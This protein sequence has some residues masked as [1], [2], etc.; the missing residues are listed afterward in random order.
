MTVANAAS[1]SS[2]TASVLPSQFKSP[3]PMKVTSV[4]LR[5]ED[6]AVL[7]VP[8]PF[9]KNTSTNSAPHVAVVGTQSS[10]T[11][12]SNLP[13]PL[14][15]PNATAC[16]FKPTF[17]WFPTGC[18][19][20][21]SP[22]PNRTFTDLVQVGVESQLLVT[23]ARSGL[24]SPLKSPRKTAE[25]PEV[26][27]VTADTGLKVPSPFPNSTPALFE[28]FT[29]TTSIFPSPFMSPVSTEKAFPPDG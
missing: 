13:S 5:T 9:P 26:E 11:A 14:R 24:L 12:K 1:G 28:P 2:V 3:N 17:D 15:S 8:S 6:F 21:P 29:T 27:V 18:P 7:N 19:K 4:E 20:V 22:F 16:E 23:T 10:T 25:L